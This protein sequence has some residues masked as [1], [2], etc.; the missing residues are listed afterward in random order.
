MPVIK[1]PP[2]KEKVNG[3]VPLKGVITRLPFT[4]PSQVVAVGAAP[5]NKVGPAVTNTL[6]VLEHPSASV[7]T[8]AWLPDESPLNV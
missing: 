6:S 8:T 5:A 7:T 2:S 4:A 3:A 1:L